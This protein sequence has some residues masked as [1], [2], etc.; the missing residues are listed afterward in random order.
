MDKIN[1]VLTKYGSKL[2]DLSDGS[3]AQVM[4]LQETIKKYNVALDVY[5]SSGEKDAKA[6]AELEG[7][8]KYIDENEEVLSNS[9]EAELA[10]KARVE[11]EAEQ[12][13]AEQE[14]A[15]KEAAATPEETE[16]KKEP[17]EEKKDSGL[18]FWI[19]SGILAAVGLSFLIKNKG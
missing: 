8:E 1:A 17:K 4:E 13:K 7:M 14:K 10:E 19:G 11:K 9:I 6:D 3:K 18:L 15:A 5:E 2:S 16:E 12:Q